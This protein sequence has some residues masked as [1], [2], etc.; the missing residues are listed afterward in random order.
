MTQKSTL[1]AFEEHLATLNNNKLIYEIKTSYDCL[2][3]REKRIYKLG[4]SNGY[5]QKRIT[6]PIR[7]IPEKY[8][9]DT[10]INEDIKKH[11][12]K[13]VAG[14]SFSKPK[15]HV[16]NSIINKVCVRY[17]V[18]KKELMITRSRRQD[19]CRARNILYNL[20]Y[21]KFNMSLSAIGRIFGNDHTTVLHGINMKRDKQ[22]FWSPEQTLWKEFE[23]LKA[24]IT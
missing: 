14:F 12:T 8:I 21:E 7:F 13:N 15:S 16:L 23:E 5:H 18:S 1:T 3:V 22:R 4:F 20:F 2:S 9:T 17:E 6:R 19:I 11:R 10:F 24:T